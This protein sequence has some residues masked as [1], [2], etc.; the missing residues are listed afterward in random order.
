MEKNIYEAPKATPPHEKPLGA[1]WIG[2]LLSVLVPSFGLIRAGEIRSGIYWMI[3]LFL[4]SIITC[5]IIGKEAFPVWMG[6]LCFGVLLITLLV[7]YVKSFKKGRMKM[8]SWILFIFLAIAWEYTPE[9]RKKIGKAYKVPTS[10]MAPTLMG[11]SPEKPQNTRDIVAVD[12]LAYIFKEPRRGDIVTFSTKKILNIS[13][14]TK[15]EAATVYVKRI[16]GMPGERIKFKDGK[17]YA[18]G[19]L[20]ENV[21]PEVEYVYPPTSASRF[22]LASRDG[23]EY[24]VSENEYLVL[25]D[26]TGNSFDSRYWGNV[27]RESFTGKVTKIIFPFHRMGSVK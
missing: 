6:Y 11:V 14:M 21:L 4:L 1:R 19:E 3:C 16:V 27:P 13:R 2:V 17:V 26:N 24:V 23:D 9:L 10:A 25:G 8:K 22:I 20:V 5:L 15:S 12:P 18:N 7:N